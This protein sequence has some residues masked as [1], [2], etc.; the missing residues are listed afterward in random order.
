MDIAVDGAD[1]SVVI[2]TLTNGTQIRV[3]FQR[4]LPCTLACILGLGV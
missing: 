4:E 3:E 1:P 2:F